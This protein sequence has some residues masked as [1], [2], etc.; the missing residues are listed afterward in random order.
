MGTEEPTPRERIVCATLELIGEV[1][2]SKLTTREIAAR[3]GVQHSLI[4]RYF[5]TKE[6]LLREVALRT[7]TG[8]AKA[9]ADATDPVDGFLRGL[10]YFLA[11]PGRAA[12]WV[13]SMLRNA[14]VALPATY[15]P[16]NAHLTQLGVQGRY[17]QANEN[18]GE[19][20]DGL[21]SPRTDPRFQVMVAVAL[22][23]GWAVIEDFAMA[24]HLGDH[25]RALVRQEVRRIL[26]ELV[27]RELSAPGYQPERPG[28]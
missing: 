20:D 8:Y 12:V 22:I 13:E 3:A 1:P 4:T 18:G 25:P 24:A 6:G 26:S 17:A 21:R 11:G 10:D 23:G 7:G 9:V 16:L 2:V 27:G 14:P 5:G 19:G 28:S 15:Q